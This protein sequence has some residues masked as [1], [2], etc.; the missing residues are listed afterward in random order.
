MTTV[1]ETKI[2]CPR[3]STSIDVNREEQIVFWT[4]QLGVSAVALRQAVRLAGC[5]LEDVVLFLR[6]GRLP[7]QTRFC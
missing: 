5:K 3:D 6:T 4:S 1:A 7:D 2:A